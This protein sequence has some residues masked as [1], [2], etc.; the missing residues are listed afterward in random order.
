MCFR[1]WEYANK[2]EFSFLHVFV[3][4]VIGFLCHLLSRIHFYKCS[5]LTHVLM[6]IICVFVIANRLFFMCLLLLCVWVIDVS[7]LGLIFEVRILPLLLQ[8]CNWGFRSFQWVQ[9]WLA[10]ISIISTQIL[11]PKHSH[12]SPKHTATTSTWKIIDWQWQIHILSP[13]A[14]ASIRNICKNG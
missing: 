12:R 1:H 6:E 2:R 13:L 10:W 4:V 5:E 14:H 3:V 8:I 7:V 11:I 9:Q